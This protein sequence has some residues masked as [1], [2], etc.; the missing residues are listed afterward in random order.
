MSVSGRGSFTEPFFSFLFDVEFIDAP[1]SSDAIV[2][3]DELI[4]A[5]GNEIAAFI[6]EPCVQGTAGM[7]MHSPELLSELIKVCKAHG[8]ITIADEVM[9]G[10]GRTGK[11]F[12]SEHLSE[13][14]DVFCLSKGLTGGTMAM[15][16]TTCT[17]KIYEAFLSDDRMKTF[18]HGHSYTANP[19]SCAAALASLDLT[20]STECS[21]ARER[22]NKKLIEL[23]SR[24]VSQPNVANV[25]VM[26]TIL[27]FD[28]VTNEET[29][30][31]NNIR[32]KAYDHFISEGVLIRPL[33]NVIYLM[34]PYCI[35]NSDLDYIYASIEKFLPGSDEVQR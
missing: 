35:S 2:Q 16:I 34:P 4:G 17:H 23:S 30:Y 1:V 9:T 32:D 12:A 29:S 6:F 27:A 8:I 19:V 15:G 10:F 20:I 11:L 18:F 26:G 7:M 5:C 28:I 14:P 33:G 24:L 13:D 22:I 25:R 21:E 31:F 3:M